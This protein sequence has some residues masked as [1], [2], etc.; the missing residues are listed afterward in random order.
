MDNINTAY[1]SQHDSVNWAPNSE[2]PRRASFVII[3]NITISF[4]VYGS[5]NCFRHR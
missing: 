5:M 3:P 2:I 1:I 4:L